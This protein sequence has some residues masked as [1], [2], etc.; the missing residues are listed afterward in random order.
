MEKFIDLLNGLKQVRSFTIVAHVNHDLARVRIA[1]NE[2]LGQS[3]SVIDNDGMVRPDYEGFL[4]YVEEFPE[5]ANNFEQS[6][7]WQGWEYDR[8][9]E[10]K[11]NVIWDSTRGG[12][13]TEPA[14]E[15]VLFTKHMN[16]VH[17]GE[18]DEPMV[19][20]TCYDVHNFSCYAGRDAT[21]LAR[22]IGQ[23]LIPVDVEWEDPEIPF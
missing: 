13:G 19:R 22:F 10:L 2:I 11:T 4:K 17:L 7:L 16:D 6:G 3:S 9:D 12:E 1:L 18:W 21:L 15:T 8:N 23:G 14:V 5:Q 20:I